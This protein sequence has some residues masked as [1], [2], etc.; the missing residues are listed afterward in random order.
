M[1]Y[2]MLS[3]NKV[4]YDDLRNSIMEELGINNGDGYHID[5]EV[6]VGFV[7]N[8]YSNYPSVKGIGVKHQLSRTGRIVV[9]VSICFDYDEDDDLSYLI[10]RVHKE[11]IKRNDAEYKAKIEDK[12]KQAKEIIDMAEKE[13]AGL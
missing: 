10:E 7:D 4:K 8:A 11:I 5:T 3:I 12:I 13:I 6:L 1:D 9:Q 2:E